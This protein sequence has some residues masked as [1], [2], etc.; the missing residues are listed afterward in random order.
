MVVLEF[1]KPVYFPFKQLYLFYFRYVLPVL[2]GL[3]SRDKAAYTYLPESVLTFP[4]G[5]RFDQELVNAKL[6][7]IKRYKQTMGIATIYLAEKL[8]Q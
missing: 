4:D 1:S 3:I 2:G 5:E 7:P 8:K 6:K